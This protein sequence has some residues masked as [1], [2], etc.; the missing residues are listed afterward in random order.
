M[1]ESIVREVEA[2]LQRNSQASSTTSSQQK[3]YGQGLLQIPVSYDPSNEIPEVCIP[4][5]PA[6]LYNVKCIFQLFVKLIFSYFFLQVLTLHTLLLIPE[7][8]NITLNGIPCLTT[9]KRHPVFPPK[10]HSMASG[11]TG[12]Q[13]GTL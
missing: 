8:R 6:V 1:K 10:P 13:S 11:K 2:F 3:N 4:Y 7:G 12:V 9:L 5:K